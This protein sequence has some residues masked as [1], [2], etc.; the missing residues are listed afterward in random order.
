[1]DYPCRNISYSE[2]ESRK[3]FP[4]RTPKAKILNLK[5]T[6]KSVHPVAERERSRVAG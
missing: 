2:Y 6:Y 4:E 1:M 3:R 5:F